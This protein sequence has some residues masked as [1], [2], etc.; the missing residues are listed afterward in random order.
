MVA[1]P[2]A[3]A[4]TKTRHIVVGKLAEDLNRATGQLERATGTLREVFASPHIDAPE[5]APRRERALKL[6]VEAGAL[7]V[8]EQ[9]K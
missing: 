8:L 2:K 4:Q 1:D 6:L 9:A 7:V 5:L 3:A